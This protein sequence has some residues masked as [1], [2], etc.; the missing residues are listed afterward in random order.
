MVG[1]TR[2]E[3]LL[4]PPAAVQFRNIGGMLAAGGTIMNQDVF[5]FP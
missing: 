1:Y 3:E 2:A 5:M 4:S